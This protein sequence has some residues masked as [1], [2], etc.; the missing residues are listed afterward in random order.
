M[1]AGTPVTTGTTTPGSATMRVTADQDV[2]CGAG[3]C[4]LNVP[5]VFDQDE[6]EGIVVVLDPAPPQRLHEVSRLSSNTS[7]DIPWRQTNCIPSA[8]WSSMRAR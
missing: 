5:E 8:Q 3:L 7:A 4:A 1:T 6:E 2:C